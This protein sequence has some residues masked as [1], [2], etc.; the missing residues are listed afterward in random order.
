VLWNFDGLYSDAIEDVGNGTFGEAGYEL[1]LENGGIEL[2]QTDQI[3]EE[4][5]NEIQDIRDQI[6]A[7]EV[8]VPVT[9]EKS[10]VEDL[11]Q[12]G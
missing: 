3:D 7:G 8:D 11:I 6:I 5:W 9:E 10:Q 2:L 4:T 1:D 12:Q